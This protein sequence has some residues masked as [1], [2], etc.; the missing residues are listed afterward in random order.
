M[1]GKE[2]ELF[3]AR[4]HIYNEDDN[5]QTWVHEVT[6]MFLY[7]D[8]KIWRSVQLR[9]V[10]HLLESKDFKDSEGWMVDVCHLLAPYGY[11]CLIGRR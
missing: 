6:E 5:I 2:Y 10:E 8:M 3:G 9:S 11:N 1:Q 4:F 7:N